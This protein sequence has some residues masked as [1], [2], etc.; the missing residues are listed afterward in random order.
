M[1][2]A[3]PQKSLLGPLL[4][5][6]MTQPAFICSNSTMKKTKGW[7]E[8]CEICD[9]CSKLTKTPERRRS[10]VFDINFKQISNC[11]GVFIVD[12]EQETA[13]W[14]CLESN[15]QLPIQTFHWIFADLKK[16]F[17][18]NRT[19][20]FWATQNNFFNIQVKLKS[21]FYYL[22][23]S[24][25]LLLKSCFSQTYQRYDSNCEVLDII[26]ICKSSFQ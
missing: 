20:I 15:M 12:F 6:A 11:S 3:I 23:C 21:S 16:S 24:M 13:G 5:Q 25:D 22:F 1:L 2:P 8:K 14:E 10:G 26:Y 17:G 7:F 4:N 9:I 18:H 19:G